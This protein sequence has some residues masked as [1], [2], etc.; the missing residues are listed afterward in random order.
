M[1][2]H[3]GPSEFSEIVGLGRT[4]LHKMQKDG[5]L[6]GQLDKYGRTYYVYSDFSNVHLVKKMDRAGNV[7]SEEIKN[8]ILSEV[9]KGQGYAPSP[10]QPIPVQEIFEEPKLTLV[11]NQ[12]KIKNLKNTTSYSALG[13]LP[14]GTLKEIIHPIE[15]LDYIGRSTW[16]ITIKTLVAQ[17]SFKVADI[18]SLIQ[19]CQTAD[20]LESYRKDTVYFVDE[21]GRVNPLL[22]EITRCKATMR[23]LAKDLHLTPDA[24]KNTKVKND[25]DMDANTAG[26]IEAVK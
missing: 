15:G 4:T 19:Y 13:E 5:K 25:V 24:R 3:Y 9:M 20:Q 26:W 21:V 23:G 16:A 10:V 8:E 7:L 1:Q 12:K 17:G 14:E 2:R 6:T 22:N 11:K 18:I